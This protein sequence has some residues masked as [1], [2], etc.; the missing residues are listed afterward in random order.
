MGRRHGG[1]V[2]K[3]RGKENLTNDTPPKKRFW[4]P[5]VCTF[6]TPPP[7]GVAAL[8]FLVKK[9]KTDQIRGV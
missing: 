2:G 4:T 8:F 9:W 3:R 6:S 7:S 1:G 5:F